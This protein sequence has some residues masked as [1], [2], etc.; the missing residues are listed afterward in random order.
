MKDKPISFRVVENA[1]KIRELQGPVYFG[2]DPCCIDKFVMQAQRPIMLQSLSLVALGGAIGASLRFLVSTTAIRMFGTV[3]PFGTLFVN[4]V[5][6]LI[7]GIAFAILSRKGIS[8]LS[9][10][11]MTGVLGGF[12][13]FSAFSLDAIALWQRGDPKLALAYVCASVFLSLGALAAGMWIAR[14]LA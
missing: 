12:T 11:L 5:G 10:F 13:T 1:A 8:G 3:F 6:S 7:M 4:V 2:A 9:L 14:S